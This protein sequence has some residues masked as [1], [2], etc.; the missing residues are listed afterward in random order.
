MRLPFASLVFACVF[1]CFVLSRLVWLCLVIAVSCL[2]LV[3]VLSCLALSYLALFRLVMSC[4][5]HVL[6]WSCLSS[7]LVSDPFLISMF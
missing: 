6:W 2:C 7:Y 1:S 5:C 3:I 4:D